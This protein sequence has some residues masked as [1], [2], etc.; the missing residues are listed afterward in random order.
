MNDDER[1]PGYFGQLLQALEEEGDVEVRAGY[2]PDSEYETVVIGRKGPSALT[3]LLL[4]ILISANPRGARMQ[5]RGVDDPKAEAALR[6]QANAAAKRAEKFTDTIDII[7]L[8]E[9]LG[10]NYQ[11]SNESIA[12]AQAVLDMIIAVRAAGDP[13]VLEW[14]FS[15]LAGNP[16]GA[17]WDE[18][19]E[20]YAATRLSRLPVKTKTAIHKLAKDVSDKET[21]MVWEKGAWDALEAATRPGYR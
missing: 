15:S 7:L 13:P 18:G 20:S 3:S 11:L 2:N 1:P 5:F 9:K 4:R 10:P 14:L 16:L 19:L 17:L 6:K 8:A 12:A 21:I